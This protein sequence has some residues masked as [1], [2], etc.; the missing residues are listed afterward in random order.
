MRILLVETDE[1]LLNQIQTELTAQN[2][3]VDVAAD[4]EI[5]WGLIHSFAYDLVILAV[6]LPKI[7]GIS[8]CRRLRE[9]GNPIL[10][11]LIAEPSHPSDRIR[12]LESGADD[13]LVKPIDRQELCA[14]IHA[15]MRRGLR[16]VSPVLS[17]GPL[18]LKPISRQVTCNGQML[19]ISRK[20][21]LLL[22][23]LLNHPQRSFTRSEIG[24]RL[25]TLDETLPSDATIKSHIRSIRRKLEK[26]GAGDLIETRYGHGYRLN[27]GL[28]FAAVSLNSPKLNSESLMDN[29]T[30][31]IW[32]ELMV[33]NARL[34]K[35]IE[36]RKQAEAELQRSERLLRNAQQAAQIGAW[37]FDFRTQETYWT[38]E[39]YLIHGLD[40]QQPA[41]KDHEIPAFIH[42]DDRQLFETEIVAL[43]VKGEPFE[44]NLRIVRKD[45]E[46]RYINARGGPVFNEAGELIKLAGTTFDVTDW[47]QIN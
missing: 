18:Q 26:A 22:E 9:V 7:D 11:M 28:D 2:F 21:Y 31:N 34:Q 35:E 43:A 30:A 8:L 41:P 5:A 13:C 44:V 10:I 27:P 47:K 12:G 23:L 45:G 36:E 39:L 25:W 37:E 15:L 32:Y 20:E 33:A 24:D 40:P 19:K 38:E 4:G 14:C 1:P 17:W 42:P 16:Q 6:S 3:L 46:I 29:I